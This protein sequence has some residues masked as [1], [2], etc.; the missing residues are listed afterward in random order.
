LDIVFS[1]GDAFF[2]ASI[3][4][5]RD[6][7][8]DIPK[9]PELGAGAWQHGQ[10]AQTNQELPHEPSKLNILSDKIKGGFQKRIKWKVGQQVKKGGR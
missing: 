4:I 3:A 1:D 5:G 2:E 8:G 9:A 7:D 10:Q 6:L